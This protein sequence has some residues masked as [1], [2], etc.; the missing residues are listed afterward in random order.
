[1]KNSMER[2]RERE[3]ERDNS[4]ESKNDNILYSS[5]IDTCLILYSTWWLT[6]I[7]N[8]RNP[9]VELTLSLQGKGAKEIIN[10]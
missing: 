1:M 7:P 9:C 2:E 6:M 8:V 3:R 4:R 10:I 5:L